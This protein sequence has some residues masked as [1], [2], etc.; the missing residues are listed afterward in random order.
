MTSS[1]GPSD[2]ASGCQGRKSRACPTL[3]PSTR[4]CQSQ[5]IYQKNSQPSGA[6]ERASKDACD[7]DYE[8]VREQGGNA[9]FNRLNS[10]TGFA[11]ALY[12]SLP[13]PVDVHP[14]IDFHPFVP[15]SPCSIHNLLQLTNVTLCSLRMALPALPACLT[16]TATLT[17]K[18]SSRYDSRRNIE[19]LLPHL[20]CSDQASFLIVLDSRDGRRRRRARVLPIN[21]V[22]LLL[23]SRT[24]LPKDGPE[25]VSR[26]PIFSWSTPAELLSPRRMTHTQLHHRPYTATNNPSPAKNV[27][28]HSYRRSA[29]S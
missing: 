2:A 27:T 13:G 9:I 8:P 12:T 14:L 25:S 24:D 17:P 19:L 4:R 29:T 20:A 15:S 6:R 23:S 10:L 7:H 26:I 18:H 11:P 22:R 3:F 5:Q 28:S 16:S 21:R 1:H